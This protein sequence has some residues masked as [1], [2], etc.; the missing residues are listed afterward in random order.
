MSKDKPGQ[1][2][3]FDS[4]SKIFRII[5]EL[6]NDLNYCSFLSVAKLK[7]ASSLARLRLTAKYHDDA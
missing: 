1:V 7:F 4:V 6:S 2:R 3:P 5:L